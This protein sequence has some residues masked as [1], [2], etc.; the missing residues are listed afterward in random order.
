MTMARRPAIG[1][2]SGM[3][4]QINLWTLIS[5]GVLIFVIVLSPQEQLP[6]LNH[7][8]QDFVVAHQERVPS[9]DLVIV[10]IDE[11]G[12]AHV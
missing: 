3:L 9:S 6:K 12:R 11:I 7:L 10:A 2:I 4:R 1:P 5:L 8:I